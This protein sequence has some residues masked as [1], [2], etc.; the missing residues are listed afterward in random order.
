[1]GAAKANTDSANARNGVLVS[2]DARRDCSPSH[3]AEEG[4]NRHDLPRWAPA[5]RFWSFPNIVNASLTSSISSSQPVRPRD[6]LSTVHF[7]P[8]RP[9][10]RAQVTAALAAQTRAKPRHRHVVAVSFHVDHAM[11]VAAAR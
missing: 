10:V 1:M 11:V 7:I 2:F 9:R 3:R 8:V 4:E 6:R 5:R